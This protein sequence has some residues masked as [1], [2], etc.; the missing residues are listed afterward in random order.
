MILLYYSQSSPGPPWTCPCRC[1]GSCRAG[2]AAPL[3]AG[4]SHGR[5]LMTTTNG[6][7][8]HKCKFGE[9]NAN[10][11]N[12]GFWSITNM[13]FLYIQKNQICGCEVYWTQS[14]LCKAPDQSLISSMAFGLVVI[15]VQSSLSISKVGGPSGIAQLGSGMGR[16]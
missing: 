5:A 8:P 10:S 6:L 12:F 2:S 14:A 11:K 9:V 15:L 16:C 3:D 4:A 7:H 1:P 13:C